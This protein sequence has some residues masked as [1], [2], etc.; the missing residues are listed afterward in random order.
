MRNILF[1]V[2]IAMH[3]G[4]DAAGAQTPPPQRAQLLIG[5]WQ[6]AIALGPTTTRVGLV[7][8]A[9]TTGGYNATLVVI[10]QDGATLPVNQ[11]TLTGSAVHLDLSS[12][13]GVYDGTL[14]DNGQDL[15]GTL[16]Q[17]MPVALN[18]R[19]VDRLDPPPTFTQADAVELRATIDRYFAVFTANDF[20]AFRQMVQVPWALWPIGAAPTV[21]ANLDDVV[22][23][24]RT[25]REGLQATDYAVSKVTQ[26]SITPLAA[27]TAMV[28][29]HWRRDKKDGSLFGEGAEIL[30]AIKAT[31]GWKV[32]GNIPR[33]L[34]HYGKTF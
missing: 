13:K 9:G 24:S 7:V 28:D 34:S 10:D 19:R 11:I 5:N 3:T 12:I 23:R 15:V 17:G 30:I 2:V 16:T 27:N 1:A 26:M 8:T 22:A 25:T 29:V 6:G 14:S 18:F 4:A 20:D 31:A 33:A 32:V 21:L